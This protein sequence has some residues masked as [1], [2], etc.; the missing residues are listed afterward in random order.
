MSLKEPE[1]AMCHCPQSNHHADYEG[2]W[3]CLT[4][5][6]KCMKYVPPPPPPKR[7]EF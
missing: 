5:F 6:C 2:H 3:A 7:R 4:T 1:C